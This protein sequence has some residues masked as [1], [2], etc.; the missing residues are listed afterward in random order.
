MICA[1]AEISQSPLSLEIKLQVPI[2]IS[3]PLLACLVSES[4]THLPC[5]RSLWTISHG[6][7]RHLVGI[8]CFLS[9]MA[10]ESK[11]T[12]R[13]LTRRVEDA[14]DWRYQRVVCERRFEQKGQGEIA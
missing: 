10:L 14:K 8:D 3:I 5:R 11:R 2:V 6:D 9:K 13:N 4:Q 1:A 7:I 12:L